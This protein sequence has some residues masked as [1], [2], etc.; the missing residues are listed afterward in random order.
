VVCVVISHINLVF[1]R[2]IQAGKVTADSV[3]DPFEV[4][5]AETM[6]N[7]LKTRYHEAFI[8]EVKDIKA[9]NDAYNSPSQ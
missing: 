9:E 3:D 2:Y 1:I 7:Y 4:S 6:L 8:S 5:D